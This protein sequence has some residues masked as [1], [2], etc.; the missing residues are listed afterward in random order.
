MIIPKVFNASLA[1]LS[2]MRRNITQKAIAVFC[3]CHENTVSTWVRHGK[4]PSFK[5]GR[6]LLIL[7]QQKLDRD[8]FSRCCE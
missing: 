6:M 8:E 1:C 4:E 7:C 3:G 5:F 2:L